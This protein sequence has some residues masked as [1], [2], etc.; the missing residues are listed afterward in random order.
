MGRKLKSLGIKILLLST[1]S[2]VYLRNL[3]IHK[4]IR[5]IINW[6]GNKLLYS[7]LTI[8]SP[9]YGIYCRLKRLT[10]KALEEVNHSKWLRPFSHRY[11]IHGLLILCALVA[12]TVNLETRRVGAETFGEGQ[13]ILNVVGYGEDSGL[14]GS[15]TLPSNIDTL[16]PP[17]A[18]NKSNESPSR[19][20]LSY[21]GEAVFQPYLPFTEISV[22]PRTRIEEYIVRDGDTLARIAIK[23]QLKIETILETNNLTARSII[24]PKQVLT[25]LPVDGIVHKIKKGEN[26]GSIAK[27]YGVGENLILSFNKISSP[28]SIKIGQD[29]IVPGGKKPQ[30]IKRAPSS[31]IPYNIPARALVDSGA[32][33]LWPTVDHRINQYFVRRHTGI[34]IKGK[35]GVPLY[36]AESG[37]VLE[38]RWAGGY[39][40]M[41]LIKHDNGLITRYGHASKNLVTK[42]QRVERGQTI[43][44][45]GSTGRSTGP[46]LHFEVYVGGQRVNPLG[47]T[48]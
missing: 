41:V 38:S 1:K 36:A 4:S 15:A 9:I 18:D 8:V 25:I 30:I 23:F 32:K 42:G 6:S 45:M 27:Q 22:A 24:R 3:L 13:L 28:T 48:R 35:T 17:T 33:L 11:L 10:I 37:T 2:L 21:T 12:V 19:T 20:Y 31:S 34:D 29:L 14:S 40:N 44:L 43:A 39:G 46:H 7:S 26:I 47:Y 16:T 5:P